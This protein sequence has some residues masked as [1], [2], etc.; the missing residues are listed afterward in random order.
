VRQATSDHQAAARK[1]AI[2]V[3]GQAA[4]LFGPSAVLYHERAAHA[5]ALGDAA[6]AE[7][8]RQRALALRPKTAWEHYALGRSLMNAGQLE[9]AQVHF[10]RAVEIQP[11]GLWPCFYQ[12]ICN[13][14]LG[15]FEEAALSFTA[16]TALAPNVAGCFLNR[17]LAFA[18]LG[19][20]E[21]ALADFDRALAL[22][23]GMAAA[24]RQ[25]QALQK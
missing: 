6:L 24:A 9:E 18:A 23:P 4:A 15:R 5:A 2:L 11:N 13:Y 16:C 20:H 10:D 1:E 14:R 17:G 25:K 21:R 19:K 22:E 12:G 8:S 7:Q 3:L